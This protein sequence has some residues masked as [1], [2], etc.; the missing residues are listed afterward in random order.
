VVYREVCTEGSETT[1]SGTDPDTLKLRGRL[2]RNGIRGIIIWVS[3]H[4]IA[5]P[6]EHQ[7]DNYVDTAGIG[8][9]N[10]L[11]PGGPSVK[12]QSCG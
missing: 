3:K 6:Y 5:K 10:M 11:L 1:K 8:G 4:I 7:K 9:R 2:N 12:K